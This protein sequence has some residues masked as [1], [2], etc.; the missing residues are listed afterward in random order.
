V[1]ELGEYDETRTLR[2]FTRPA[3]RLAQEF[4]DRGIVP[5]TAVDILEAVYGPSIS[6]VQASGFRIPQDLIPLI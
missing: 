4:R 6:W 5:D 2:G 1:Y 3:N